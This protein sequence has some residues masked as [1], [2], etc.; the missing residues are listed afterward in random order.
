[1]EGYIRVEVQK[2]TSLYRNAKIFVTGYSLG[3]ALAT[4]GAADLKSVYG[5]V[6][7]LYTFRSSRVWNDG[8]ATMITNSIPER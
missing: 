2:L 4:I 8:F 6:D 7:Q 1:M 3:A 5:H